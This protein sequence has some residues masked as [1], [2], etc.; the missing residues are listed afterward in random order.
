IATFHRH[1]ECQQF[2][3]RN[4]R[5]KQ[6]VHMNATHWATLSNFCTIFG[7]KVEQTGRGWYIQYRPVQTIQQ[8]E[9]AL[10][11]QQQAAA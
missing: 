1:N 3:S 8:Q 6:H 4:I 7:A 10:R 2:V 11:R 9:E 5:D